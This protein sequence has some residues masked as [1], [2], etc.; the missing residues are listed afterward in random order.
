M[1]S[2]ALVACVVLGSLSPGAGVDGGGSMSRFAAG[3]IESQLPQSLDTIQ[4]PSANVPAALS[5]APFVEVSR[6]GIE[7]NFGYI[8][9]LG[10]IALGLGESMIALLPSRGPSPA[11]AFREF[12][13]RLPEGPGDAGARAPGAV[14]LEFEGAQP[15]MPQAYGSRGAAFNFLLGNDPQAW[16]IG[17]DSYEGVTYSDLYPGIDLH[18]LGDQ[19]GLKYEFHLAPG[20]N[21]SLIRVNVSGAD[22][23]LVDDAARMVIRAGAATIWDAPPLAF[24]RSGPVDCGYVLLGPSSFGFHC[25]AWNPEEL[26]TIDPLIWAT[27]VGG[28][29]WDLVSA[30]AVDTDGA[31]FIAGT[32]GSPDLPSSA[33]ALSANLTGTYDAYVAKLDPTGSYL[34]YATYLG[35]SGA[36]GA[37]HAALSTSGELLVAGT[38]NSTDFPTTPGAW[39]TSNGGASDLYVAKVNAQ[40]TGLVFAT[41]LGFGPAARLGGFAQ[42]ADGTTYL[43]GTANDATFPTTPGS[44]DRVFNN[45]TGSDPDA[46]VAHLSVDGTGLLFSTLLG[47]SDREEGRAVAA[48]SSG[49]VWVT[50]QTASD[51][52]PVSANASK[53]TKGN[54]TGAFASLIDASGSSLRYSTFIGGSAAEDGDAVAIASNGDIL[55]AGYTNSQDFPTTLGSLQPVPGNTG[56]G[57]TADA[58]LM[59]LDAADFSIR[60]STYIGGLLYDRPS[61]LVLDAQDNVYVAG[62]SDPLLFPT[63]VNAIQNQSA[64]GTRDAFL[65]KVNPSGTAMAYGT[66]FG[67]PG[68]EEV[69]AL[70]VGPD[71]SATLAIRSNSSALPVTPG[72]LDQTAVG[73]EGYVVRIG[74]PIPTLFLETP[75]NGTNVTVPAVWVAGLTDVGA[76]LTVSG[77]RVAVAGNGSYGLLVPLVPGENRILAVATA[78]DGR[79]KNVSV[80][81]RYDDPIPG[82]LSQV[83]AQSASLNATYQELNATRA[84]LANRTADLNATREDLIAMG[85]RL[86]LTMSQLLST[87]S[88]HAATA[89]ALQVAIEEVERMQEQ[90]IVQGDASNATLERLADTEGNLSDA[91]AIMAELQAALDLSRAKANG[92]AVAYEQLVHRID[93]LERA[94]ASAKDDLALTEE[95]LN[96]TQADLDQA[97][98]DAAAATGVVTAIIGVVIGLGATLAALTWKAYRRKD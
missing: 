65:V 59:R 11:D 20:A 85:D 39:N 70:G 8:A 13:P 16:M 62:T 23:L 95:A 19:A 49:N 86:N 21:P 52:F 72:A 38:T 12:L 67:G 27:F 33:S 98:A 34:E 15:A 41:L 60:W 32:T 87:Q 64:G 44:Y 14:Y 6:P 29:G 1:Q 31:T 58:Y 63:T 25:A 7:D 97:R 68:N 94:L 43:T 24:Q 88:E 55:L 66:L 35:G 76:D 73:Q 10:G 40:G 3:G 46:F 2:A 28:S 84:D 42:G 83:A 61:A 92:S 36:D 50:G 75:P 30:V 56:A 48:D 71:A 4:P 17:A 47:G 80:V 22:G 74:I 26:L 90:A 37:T 5:S 51:D 57:G 79:T 93:E 78:P 77:V 89:A 53:P 9:S 54:A 69:T 81:V 96:Q 45:G 91:L 82:L 18:L